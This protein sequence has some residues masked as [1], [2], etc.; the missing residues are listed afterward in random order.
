M[1]KK[2]SNNK[3]YISEPNPSWF[4]NKSNEPNNPKW[5]NNNWLKSRFH[6][7][8]A[9]YDNFNNKGFGILRV[10]NDDLVQPSRGFGEHPHRDMEICTYVVEGDL[11]H[12]DSMG[13]QETLTRGAVQFMTAGQ[14]VQHSEHN[15]NPSKP[16]RFLQLWIN[17]RQRGLKPNYGSFKGDFNLRHNQFHHVVSD[18]ADPSTSTP[19]KI[20]QDCN[21]Y[22]T[23]LDSNREVTFDIKSDRQ[24]Y[25][26]CIEGSV[27]ITSNSEKISLDRHDAL[28]GLGQSLLKFKST[29]KTV[30][31]SKE[32]TESVYEST[33]ASHVMVIEMQKT[34]KGRSDL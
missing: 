26:V 9:E 19:I 11:T 3:L 7:S 21:I 33:T 16:L 24:V 27:D 22:V 4:G 29:T 10:L 17:P 5:T 30:T 32:S 23:E 13:T 25:V 20:N 8:F 14:G 1:L 18:V 12:Q 28:E 31:S 6:F 34:G 15:L 2:I